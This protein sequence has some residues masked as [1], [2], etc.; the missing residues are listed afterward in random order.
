MIVALALHQLSNQSPSD[1][2][3]ASSC[4]DRSIWD[5]IWNCL[6][7][8]FACTWIAVHPNLP[9]PDERP[10]LRRLKIF[11]LALIAPELIVLWAM[12]QWV[13]SRK[14]AHR[15]KEYGWTQAHG[16]FV[17]MGGFQI[18]KPT[19]PSKFFTL[20]S[21]NI[22]PYLENHDIAI[23]EQEIWDRSKG[24][25]LAKSLVVIQVTWFI[26][27]VAARALQHLAITELEIVTL[28]FSILNF[29][30]Y[31]CWWNKPLDVICPV[32]VTAYHEP[33]RHDPRMAQDVS[34]PLL[35]SMTLVFPTSDDNLDSG[36]L[37]SRFNAE[38]SQ[39]EPTMIQDPVACR[40]PMADQ[41]TSSSLD[42][43][44]EEGSEAFDSDCGL[45]PPHLTAEAL[46][47]DAS[48]LPIDTDHPPPLNNTSSL[49]LPQPAILR[50]QRELLPSAFDLSTIQEKDSSKHVTST[51]AHHRIWSRLTIR[52]SMCV[53]FVQH[54]FLIFRH[55]LSTTFHIVVHFLT[56]EFSKLIVRGG[57]VRTYAFGTL[58]KA[59]NTIVDNLTCGVAVMFG[60]IHC[61]V[62]RFEFPTKSEGTIWRTSSL[63]VA[64]LPIYAIILPHIQDFLLNSVQLRQRW[65]RVRYWLVLRLYIPSVQISKLLYMSARLLLLVQMFVLLMKPDT[66]IYTPIHWVTYIPHF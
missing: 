28:A 14:L 17:I 34:S 22:E 1:F 12:R 54:K 64:F 38:H 51:V 60:A 42:I 40:E 29:M 39:P 11:A 55:I 52:T 18:C 10:M 24:D 47:R 15:Y 48:S 61:L 8:I 25:I 62:W 4:N 45:S 35:L 3:P 6:S 33:V 27:Q 36:A 44:D 19:E 21:D 2:T 66:G 30:I 20:D 23:S 32:R 31:F 46:Y 9:K 16:F 63:I 56:G 5:I 13:S 41:D 43:T 57:S 65:P 7:I 37:A 59:E 50:S 49:L 26:L 53:K 58:T